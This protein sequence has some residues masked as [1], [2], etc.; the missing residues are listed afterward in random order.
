MIGITIIE[1]SVGVMC[2]LLLNV[3]ADWIVRSFRLPIRKS[4]LEC[5]SKQINKANKKINFVMLL[6]VKLS[7]QIK[8][9]L[10]HFGRQPCFLNLCLTLYA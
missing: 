4:A 6:T 3:M 7:V 10:S 9:I 1:R 5:H 8:Q 2:I